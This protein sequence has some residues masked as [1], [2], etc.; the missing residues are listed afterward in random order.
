MFG[1]NVYME[2]SEYNGGRSFIAG[3]QIEQ[4]RIQWAYNAQPRQLINSQQLVRSYRCIDEVIDYE[5]SV[6]SSMEASGDVQLNEEV[7]MSLETRNHRS[8][9]APCILSYQQLHLVLFLIFYQFH[10]TIL[11]L[12]WAFE[13]LIQLSPAWLDLV[14]WLVEFANS[15]RMRQQTAERVHHPPACQVTV[16]CKNQKVLNVSVVFLLLSCE[17]LY[18]VCEEWHGTDSLIQGFQIH[19]IRYFSSH[20]SHLSSTNISDPLSF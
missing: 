14:L 6:G 5:G 2:N 18:G 10:R 12:A 4:A 19:M 9:C 3:D 8:S 1:A 11:Q 16:C 13:S 17:C 15:W 7:V 20:F